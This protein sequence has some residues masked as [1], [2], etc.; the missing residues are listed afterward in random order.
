M[1]PKTLRVLSFFIRTLPVVDLFTG[2]YRK[3]GAIAIFQAVMYFSGFWGF[4]R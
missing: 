4:V 3:M 2:Y 1:S